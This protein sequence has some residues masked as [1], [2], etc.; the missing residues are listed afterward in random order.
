MTQ[1]CQRII[2]LVGPQQ[3]K[4]HARIPRKVRNDCTHNIPGGM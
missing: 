3:Q 2:E 4:F 1:N